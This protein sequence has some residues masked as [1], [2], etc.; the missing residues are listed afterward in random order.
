MDPFPMASPEALRTTVRGVLEGSAEAIDAWFRAEHPEVYR[1]C[2]GFLADAAEAEDLAQDAMLHLMDRLEAWDGAR[3]YRGWR[4]AVVLNLCRDRRRRN[5][6]RERA[7]ARAA[8]ARLAAEP[9]AL[10]DPG[11]EMERAEVQRVLAD[12]LAALTPREREA[13]VLRDLEGLPTARVAET[14]GVTEGTVRSLLTLGRR[15][16]RGIL[17]ERL[18]GVAGGGAHG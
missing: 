2:F 6:A 9:G 5:A 3:S 11:S 4:N 15:R 18:P 13:F 8:E 10:P 16:L 17:A 12:S 1:L 14:L 7:H